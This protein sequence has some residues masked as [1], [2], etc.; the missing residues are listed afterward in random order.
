M[1]I[2][3]KEKICALWICNQGSRGVGLNDLDD[4]REGIGKQLAEAALEALKSEGIHKVNM[5]VFVHNEKGNAIWKRMRFTKRMDLV[6]RD[7][8]LIF[9]MSGCFFY[10]RLWPMTYLKLCMGIDVYGNR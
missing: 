5:V 9:M 2:E 7:R 6:Y 10:F 1:E 4:S 3:K 8:A